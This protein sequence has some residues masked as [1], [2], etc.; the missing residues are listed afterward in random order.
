MSEGV[1][2]SID[3]VVSLNEELKNKP[4]SDGDARLEVWIDMTRDFR[5]GATCVSMLVEGGVKVNVTVSEELSKGKIKEV[6]GIAGGMGVGDVFVRSYHG[7]SLYDVLG[8][9]EGVEEGVGGEEIKRAYYKAVKANHPDVVGEIGEDNILKITEAYEI[10]K[11]SEKRRLYDEEFV[12][13]LA[14]NREEEDF[15]GKSNTKMA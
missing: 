9:E 8:V 7:E 1:L 3:E 4:G 6:K 15:F 10:L 11:D 13:D 2:D 5:K 12:A 14:C